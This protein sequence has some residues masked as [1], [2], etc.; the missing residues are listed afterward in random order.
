MRIERE[1]QRRGTTSVAAGWSAASCLRRRFYRADEG[2]HELSV[3]LRSDGVNIDAMAGEEFAG[4]FDAIDASGFE[5]Y[6][7]EAGGGEGAAVFVFFQC[8]CDTAD[9]EENVLAN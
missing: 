5:G 9:P 3:H 1:C 6:L 7:L 2:A 4:V 8:A